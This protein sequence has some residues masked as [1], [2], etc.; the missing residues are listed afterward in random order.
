[1][2]SASGADM[3]PSA[4]LRMLEAMHEDDELAGMLV[5]IGEIQ[6]G[7]NDGLPVAALTASGVLCVVPLRET[8]KLC[9][10]IEKRIAVT[11]C[12]VCALVA[13]TLREVLAVDAARMRP[14]SH[15]TMH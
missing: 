9:E 6:S 14:P 3:R 11:E 7:P 13:K 1:M 4:F 2:F 8:E 10:S 15:E 12:E 5:E